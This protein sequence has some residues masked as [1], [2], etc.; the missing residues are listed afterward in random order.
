[1]FHDGITDDGVCVL[2]TGFGGEEVV[3]VFELGIAVVNVCGNEKAVAVNFGC[4][5]GVEGME[6]VRKEFWMT[7]FGFGLFG[8]MKVLTS[9]G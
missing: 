4:V 2:I 8:G 6:V 5:G 3:W 9:W 1:M 7:L